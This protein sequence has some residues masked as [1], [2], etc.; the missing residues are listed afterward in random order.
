MNYIAMTLKRL[1]KVS[2]KSI[3]TSDGRIVGRIVDFITDEGTG[4]IMEILAVPAPG[5]IE[6]L[7]KDMEGRYIIP[8]SIVRPGQDFLVVDAEKL[9]RLK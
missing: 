1:K 7:K 3:A 9:R 6:N 2:G 8:Y 5:K 4:S